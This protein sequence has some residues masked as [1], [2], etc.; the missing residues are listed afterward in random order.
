[1]SK[2][3]AILATQNQKLA[4]LGTFPEKSVRIIWDN[5]WFG[6]CQTPLRVI[7]YIDD[8]YD[9]ATH[10]KLRN[11]QGPRRAAKLLKASCPP[12]GRALS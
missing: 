1:M 8:L 11:P 2:K 7:D 10:R 5:A 12:F 9:I 6:L 3:A 4:S